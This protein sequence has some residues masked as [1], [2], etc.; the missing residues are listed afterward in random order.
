MAVY[1]LLDLKKKVPHLFKGQHDGGVLFIALK[2][3]YR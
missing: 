3:M 2:T 1:T